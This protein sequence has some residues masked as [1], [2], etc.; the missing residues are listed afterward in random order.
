VL[1]GKAKGFDLVHICDHSNSMYLKSTGKVPVAITAH[2]LLAVRSGLGEIPQNPTGFTGQALQR[3]ILRGLAGAKNVISVSEK[4]KLD[5]L[6]LIKT[7]PEVSVIYH[8]LNWKFER[9]PQSEINAVRELLGIAEGEE[10]L[11]HVGGN[12]WYKNRVGAM[13]MFAEMKKHPRFARVKLVMAGKPWTHAM[14]NQKVQDAIEMVAPTNEQIRALYSGA[15]AFLFPSLEE[16]FGWPILEAQACGA[17]VITSDRA[18]MTE[19]AGDAALLIDPA[20]SITAGRKIA[21]QLEADPGLLERLREAGYENLK[22]F[23]E[24]EVMQRYA[25]AYER[26]VARA[27]GTERRARA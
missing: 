15:M 16:G 3:W 21:V 18:P 27:H 12:Q 1:P 13:Q 11:L 14:R 25:A 5:L 7:R 4:T 10:Y 22:R 8:S 24:D 6:A 23:G 26:A 9:A 20:D 2:D 19:V 17:P